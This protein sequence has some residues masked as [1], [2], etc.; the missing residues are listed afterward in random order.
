MM[1]VCTAQ[2][3]PGGCLQQQA[4]QQQQSTLRKTMAAGS[5]RTISLLMA[6]S[7]AA[8]HPF[9]SAKPFAEFK[10][11]SVCDRYDSGSNSGINH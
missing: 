11:S 4:K 5:C 1:A 7:C 10:T 2:A 8:R 9:E 6:K 3:L